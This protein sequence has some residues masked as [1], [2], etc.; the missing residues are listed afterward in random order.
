MSTTPQPNLRDPDE[1]YELIWKPS[2]E[3]EDGTLNV[4]AVKETLYSFG[5][6]LHNNQILYTYLTDGEIE[7]PFTNPEEVMEAADKYAASVVDDSIA[8]FATEINDTAQQIEDREQ[9][10][11]FIEEI[12]ET[13]MLDRT[14]ETQE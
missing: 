3:N 7:D 14:Q 4:Q 9:R 13:V 1:V 2:V 11:S 10:L 8:A 12:F 6:M 5:A